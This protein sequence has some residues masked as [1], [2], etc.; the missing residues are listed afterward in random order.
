MKQIDSLRKLRNH[1]M[2]DFEAG[3]RD[4]EEWVEAYSAWILDGY[5][6]NK[7]AKLEDCNQIQPTAA[8]VVAIRAL[9]GSNYGP[10]MP[11][12]WA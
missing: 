6:V 10:E 4:R 12:P 11:S 9:N 7:N 5:H 2:E 8:T 3:L 1:A